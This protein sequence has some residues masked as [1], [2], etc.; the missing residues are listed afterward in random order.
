MLYALGVG[1]LQL[2]LLPFNRPVLGL[3]IGLLLAALFYILIPFFVTYIPSQSF[4]LLC[5]LMSFD[6]Y[7]QSWVWPHILMLINTEFD[8]KEDALKLGVWSTN[9]NVG[10]IVGF[11]VCQYLVL[12]N[13][14]PWQVSMIIIS[15]FIVA[16]ALLARCNLEELEKIQERPQ[17]RRTSIVSHN[18]SLLSEGSEGDVN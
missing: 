16:V 12:Y 1:Y 10:N 3:T 6:G 9:T 14:L 13:G 17:P 11:V 4:V 15:I 2:S 7:F 18:R 5:V 8:N